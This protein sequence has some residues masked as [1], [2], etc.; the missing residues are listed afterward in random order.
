MNDIN[1]VVEATWVRDHVV[2]LRFEDGTT[3]EAD[4][5]GYPSR[6]P[7]FGPLADVAY[8][9]QFAIV[10]GTLSW[11]NGADIAPERL[12]ELVLGCRAST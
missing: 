3:G 5:G 8:F 6:G 9:K 12:Y 11:P 1:D 4:L 7:I 2:L 10:G